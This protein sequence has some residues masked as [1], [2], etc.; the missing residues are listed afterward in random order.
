MFVCLVGMVDCWAWAG[1]LH[2]N[3]RAVSGVRCTVHCDIKRNIV[4][5]CSSRVQVTGCPPP[6][7]TLSK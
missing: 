5:E 7:W 2:Y 6:Q 3:M 1:C 4:Q